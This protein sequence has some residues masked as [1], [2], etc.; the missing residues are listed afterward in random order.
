MSKRDSRVN[1][2]SSASSTAKKRK[3]LKKGSIFKRFVIA[4]LAVGGL[5]QLVTLQALSQTLTPAG[6]SIDNRATGTYVDPANP[7]TPIN[8]TSNTVSV[9]TAPVAGITNTNLAFTDTNGNSINGGD[10][11]FFDFTVRN[12]GNYTTTLNIPAAANISSTNFTI[13]DYQV[14]LTGGT[15]F[16]V[17]IPFGAGQTAA[18]S[19]PLVGGLPTIAPG[20]AITIRVRGTVPGGTAPGS[21]VTVQLGNTAPNDN[22]PATQN[23]P[24]TGSPGDVT[25][26]GNNP[27]GGQAP[28]NGQREAAATRTVTVGS[29]VQNVAL[30]TILKSRALVVPNTVATTDDQITYRLDMRVESTSP[31]INFTPTNLVGTA[32]NG[33]GATP[34]ILVSD[35]VPLQ[36]IY[37]PGSVVAPAGWTPVFS[38]TA[39]AQTDNVLT[40]PTWSLVEPASPTRIGFIYTGGT[41][42]PPGYTTAPDLQGF[43]F[44]VTTNGLPPAGGQINNL[45]Q[46]FGQTQGD[47]TNRIVY[48]ESGDQNPNNFSGAA[49]GTPPDPLGTIYAPGAGGGPTGAGGGLANPAVHGSDNNNNNSGIDSG[50]PGGNGTAGTGGEDNIIS[51]TP[52]VGLINGPNTQANATGPTNNTD[53]FTNLAAPLTGPQSVPGTTIDPPAIVFN[54]TY[55]NSSPTNIDNV[56]LFPLA[57]NDPTASNP[58]GRLQTEMPTGTTVTITVPVQPNI[59]VAQTVTFTYNAGTG[60]YTQTGGAPILMNGIT[61]GQNV[62]YTV[63]VDLPAGSAISTDRF[64]AVGGGVN[65]AD[66]AGYSVPIVAFIDPDTTTPNFNPA[67]DTVRNT[68]IDRVYLGFVQL[69]KESCLEAGTGATPPAGQACPAFS[70]AIKN[71]SPGNV[72][73]YRVSYVNFSTPNTAGAA[74]NGTLTA[75]NLVV[76]DDGVVAP[77]NWVPFTTHNVGT[78]ATLG[79]LQFFNAAAALGA[80][81]PASGAVV[82]RYVNNVGNIAPAPNPTTAAGSLTFRRTVN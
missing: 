21:P 4:A 11:L 59:P 34:R 31:N 32:V 7:G 8:T 29:S 57:P 63:T 58:T 1:S 17:G 20:A 15:T 48:D 66:R 80:A 70:A 10:P 38:T 42:L 53:D 75:N 22:S 25:T 67:T 82:T 61:P 36:T 35:A 28:V 27:V 55:Q 62:N 56:R 79:T 5:G 54:N 12:T 68:T 33:L 77:N 72:I 65:G 76:Q 26:S 6:T 78:V 74:G 14:D 44:T 23:Q 60:T 18:F 52:T 43:R 69:L 46:V 71:S 41:S 40:T 30:A 50:L 49:G 19:T 64:T 39:V 81:D 37:N 3:K 24:I 9:V 16:P 45:A 47:L 13:A 2:L 73:V 51:I